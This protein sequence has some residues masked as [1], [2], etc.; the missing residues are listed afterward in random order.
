MGMIVD[1]VS[2][3]IP[4]DTKFKRRFACVALAALII[5]GAANA[6]S[7]P[8]VDVI[9]EGGAAVGYTWRHERSTYRGAEGGLDNLPMYLYEGE[10][11]YLHA[12]RLGLK[13]KRDD[14]RFDAFLHYRLEGFTVDRR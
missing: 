4:R 7:D 13:F 3:N 11:A 2:R 1:E 5:P 6:S 10:R 9:P 14:W 8:L 12:T